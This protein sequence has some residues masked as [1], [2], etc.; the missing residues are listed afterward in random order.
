MANK[1]TNY[2]LTKPLAEEFY[3]VGVQ[4]GNMDIIDKK[5][6]EVANSIPDVSG[7][8]A[9]HNSNTSAHS[10]IR[11]TISDLQT[12][13]AG[14]ASGSH[15]HAPTDLTSAVPV[16]KG[17]TGATDAATARTN[18][19]ITPANIGAASLGSDGKVPSSQLP[20][21]SSTK[22][23]TVT[24]L[25]TGWTE[26]SDGRYYQTVDASDVTADTKV[27]MVDVDLSTD[28]VD[29]K[30]AY[31]EAWALPSANEVDQGAGKLTFYAWEIPTVNIPVNVGVM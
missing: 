10:D 5:L 11:K 16:T 7:Q 19:G 31:L 13:V 26:G 2:G 9:T 28:D 17:G 3:D 15:S 18:L 21:I 22:N 14:K 24:L 12:T 4:N 29:A 23:T 25:A 20:E 6:K 1:T 27:V 8:I 30:I